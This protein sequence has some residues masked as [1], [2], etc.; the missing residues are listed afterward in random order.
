MADEPGNQTPN[1][2]D[3][4]ETELRAMKVD[5]LRKEAKDEGLS[6][7]SGMRKG[8]LVD[9]VAQAKQDH[10][11]GSHAESH[12]GASDDASDDVGAGPDGGRIRTG[13]QTSKSLKYA[14][15]ITSP[16]EDP[17]REG[18]SLATTHHEVIKQWAEARN[19]RPATVEGTEHG[20]HLGV[21]RFD[22][23]E[24]TDKLRHVSWDE[25]FRTF[26]QRQLNFVYQEQRKDGNQS[27]FFILESPNR[28]DA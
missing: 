18:R 5:E 19:A 11:D 20:D 22:F 21:L 10:A 2:P 12:A 8:E 4:S 7:T 25:W 26:D 14:Q 16:E 15:E 3:V 24:D 1:T 13:D 9:A 23:N 27:N 17:E 28:E 6:G